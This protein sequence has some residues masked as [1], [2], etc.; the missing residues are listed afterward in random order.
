MSGRGVGPRRADREA[1]GWSEGP[2]RFAV[3]QGLCRSVRKNGKVPR[4]SPIDW[5]SEGEC[6]LQMCPLVRMA[7]ALSVWHRP[8]AFYSDEVLQRRQYV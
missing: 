5:V 1:E 4:L 8:G 6:C 3:R 7:N 2:L